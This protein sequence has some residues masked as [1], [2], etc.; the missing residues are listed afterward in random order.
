M[1]T[2]AVSMQYKNLWLLQFWFSDCWR[3]TLTHNFYLCKFLK[4]Q[5]ALV[6]NAPIRQSTDLD[7][8]KVLIMHFCVQKFLLLS[9]TAKF[10]MAEKI[11]RIGHKMFF[12]NSNDLKYIFDNG[13]NNILVISSDSFYHFLPDYWGIQNAFW[14]TISMSTLG[15][16]LF[17]FSGNTATLVLLMQA[18]SPPFI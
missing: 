3:K 9:I 11:N 10:I 6:T 13:K 1:K 7:W 18:F 4:E 17:F 15:N 8:N 12:S 5:C 16:F 14:P 2:P